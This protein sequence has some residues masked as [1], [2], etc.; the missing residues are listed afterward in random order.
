MDTL[1]RYRE[2]VKDIIRE[3]A[4]YTPSNAEIEVETIFDESNDHY[5][6]IH[7]GWSGSHRIQG[8]VIHIDI[9]NGKIW[10]QFDG[11]ADGVATELVAAGVPKDHIVLAWKPPNRRKDTDYAVA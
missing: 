7:I 6:L 8:A 10:I 11:T 2:L 5:E 3:H 9:R 4:R 1:T